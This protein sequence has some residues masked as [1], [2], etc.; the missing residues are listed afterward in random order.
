MSRLKK[1]AD[2]KE[3]MCTQIPGGQCA[4]D[5]VDGLLPVA[6]AGVG[7]HKVWEERLRSDASSIAVNLPNPGRP[8]SNGQDQPSYYGLYSI[9]SAFMRLLIFSS[10]T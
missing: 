2:G 8:P 9:F 1:V 6:A 10:R 3:S 5:Q 7:S 4:F